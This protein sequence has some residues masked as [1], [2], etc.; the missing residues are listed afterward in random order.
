LLLLWGSRYLGIPYIEDNSWFTTEQRREQ[1]ERYKKSNTLAAQD[2]IVQRIH[3]IRSDAQMSESGCSLASSTGLNNIHM[4]GTSSEEEELQ[5]QQQRLRDE[6]IAQHT[7]TVGAVAIDAQGNLAAATS[8]GGRTNK[9]DGRI[10][11]TPIVGA[12]GCLGNANSCGPLRYPPAT[13]FASCTQLVTQL[14]WH[15]TLPVAVAAPHTLQAPG[16]TNAAQ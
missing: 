12:G 15:A 4:S 8:T 13:A 2:E 16:Q 11:D 5:L 7:Q 14:P 9:W 10:G 1:W 3:A 6:E